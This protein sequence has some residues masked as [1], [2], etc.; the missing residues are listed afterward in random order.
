MSSHYALT[1]FVSS[2]TYFNSFNLCNYPTKSIC[3]YPNL[4][5]GWQSVRERLSNMFKVTPPVSGW[6]K[7]IWLQNSL[8]QPLTLSLCLVNRKNKKG[9][10][11]NAG[12]KIWNTFWK[13]AKGDLLK[14][15]YRRK[16]RETITSS[17]QGRRKGGKKVTERRNFEAGLKEIWWFCRWSYPGKFNNKTIARNISQTELSECLT[18]FT[19]LIYSISRENNTYSPRCWWV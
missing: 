9:E 13:E 1:P 7:A 14:D 17:P 15:T 5:R 2:F 6:T 16:R 10:T 19:C 12:E 18:N 3:Y 4:Q 11:G 8:S